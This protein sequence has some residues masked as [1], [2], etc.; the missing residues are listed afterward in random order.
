M[1]IAWGKKVSRQFVD[2]VIDMAR[3]LETD[4]CYLMACM[5]FETGGTFRPDIYNKAGSGAVGLIQF[6]PQTATMLGVTSP[7][8]ASLSA[9]EQLG[10]VLRYFLPFKGRLR[11]LSDVYMAILWPSAVG[12]P[13]NRVIFRRSDPV[14]PKLYLQNHGLDLNKDGEITKAECTAKVMKM[15][16]KGLGDSLALEV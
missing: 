9:E 10:F 8:L 13:E 15:L 1:R 7:A 12:K 14:R 5:A 11:S 2:R 4:P 16:N 3:H 6:M